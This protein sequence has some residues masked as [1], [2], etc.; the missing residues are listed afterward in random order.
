LGRPITIAGDKANANHIADFGMGVLR[1]SGLVARLYG[2]LSIAEARPQFLRISG[3][4]RIN[5]A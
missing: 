2:G 4:A 1:A 5:V 3:E